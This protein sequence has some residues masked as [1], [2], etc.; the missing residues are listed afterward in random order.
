MG[1]PIA[2]GVTAAIAVTTTCR[3]M[4]SDFN[5]N[6]DIE[7][8][9]RSRSMKVRAHAPPCLRQIRGDSLNDD[10]AFQLLRSGTMNRK[11]GRAD[12]DKAIRDVVPSGEEERAERFAREVRSAVHHERTHPLSV[13]VMGQTGVGKSS[14]LNALFDAGFRTD[15][16]RPCTKVPTMVEQTT[17]HGQ[18]IQ[19]WDMPGLGE[20]Q[21][22][23]RGYIAEYQNILIN[24]DICI[25]A[26]HADTRS[27]SIEREL[28]GRVTRGL[29]PAVS[30]KFAYVLTKI[31]LAT[32]SPW[33]LGIEAEG[34]KFVP[35]DD[36]LIRQKIDF[37][38]AELA[39][40][41]GTGRVVVPRHSDDPLVTDTRFSYTADEVTFVGHLGAAEA[42][43]LAKTQGDRAVNLIGRIRRSSEVVPCSAYYRYNLSQVLEQVLSRLSDTAVLRFSGAV[44]V[45]RLDRLEPE[46]AISMRNFRV[47]DARSKRRKPVLLDPY[48]SLSSLGAIRGQ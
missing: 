22:A 12:L 37:F 39:A 25:W 32:S 47:V 4:C 1:A 31:D 17:D 23:D 11:K 24:S 36:E 13:A 30:G 28:I 6:C 48:A 18:K 29:D 42:E 8:P 27:V 2:A 35:F 15:P 45:E 46:A 44:E 38:E 41:M 43:R 33:T 21:S 3:R 10:R 5:N 14:L 16:V 20:D 7:R 19:F 26:V 40:E 9:Q 34:A